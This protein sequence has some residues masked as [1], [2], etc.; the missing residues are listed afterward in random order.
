MEN[1]NEFKAKRNRILDLSALVIAGLF[2]IILGI[3]VY[4]TEGLL[5]YLVGATLIGVF[6]IVFG[7]YYY[8]NYE[9]LK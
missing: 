3:F 7:I 8:I 4:M 1:S 6:L 9:W 5:G 2:C